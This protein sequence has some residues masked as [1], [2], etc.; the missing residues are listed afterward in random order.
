MEDQSG[1]DETGTGAAGRRGQLCS[2]RMTTMMTF[3]EVLMAGK[4]GAISDIIKE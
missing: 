2:S 3:R 1:D 4:T